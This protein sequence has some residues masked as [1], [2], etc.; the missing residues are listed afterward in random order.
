V[1]CPSEQRCAQ[2][3]YY[4]ELF[5]FGQCLGWVDAKCPGVCVDEGLLVAVEGLRVVFEGLWVM[6]EDLW[7]GVEVV[8]VVDE[9]L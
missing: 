3:G 4:P 8:C 7:V 6:V 1:W 5:P 2:S 9:G